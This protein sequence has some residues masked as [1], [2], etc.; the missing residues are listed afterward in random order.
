MR[1]KA[2]NIPDVVFLCFVLM[3]QVSPG[4][5]QYTE[6]LPE[7]FVTG[8]GYAIATG[9]ATILSLYQARCLE[10]TL[11]GRLPAK[12]DCSYTIAYDSKGVSVA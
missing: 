6:E 10:D 7:D 8:Y 3:R 2:Q 5:W 4:V 11:Q 1:V 9:S 12:T